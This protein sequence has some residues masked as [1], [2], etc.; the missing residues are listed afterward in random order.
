MVNQNDWWLTV[1]MTAISFEPSWSGA[2]SSRSFLH[3]VTIKLPLIRMGENCED[4]SIDGSS[5]ELIPGF[6]TFAD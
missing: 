5:K 2:V 1:P 3:V 6:R 4:I